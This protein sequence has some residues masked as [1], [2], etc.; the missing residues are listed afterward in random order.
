MSITIVNP[1]QSLLNNLETLSADRKRI[2]D[3]ITAVGRP[4]DLYPFQWVQIMAFVLEY[5]PDLILELGRGYGNST[6]AFIETCHLMQS[7]CQVVS[8]CLSDDWGTRTIPN[9]RKVVN[10][11]WFSPVKAYIVNLFDYDYSKVLAGKKRVVVFWDAHGFDIAEFV[12]GHILLMIK[13]RDHLVIMHDISDARYVADSTRFYGSNGIWK[14]KNTWDGPRIHV[15]NIDSCVEQSVAALDFCT[16]NR[17]PFHSADESLIDISNE[18]WENITKVFGNDMVSRNGHWFWFTLNESTV[19][20]TF[21]KVTVETHDATRNPDVEVTQQT[22]SGIKTTTPSGGALQHLATLPFELPLYVH[23]YNNILPNLD[24][25]IED[26]SK[27][28]AIVDTGFDIVFNPTSRKDHLATPYFQILSQDDGG[29]PFVRVI[30][31]YNG[32]RGGEIYLQDDSYQFVTTNL[33]SPLNTGKKMKDNILTDIITLDKQIQK[34]RLMIMSKT[35]D[36][37]TLPSLIKI[38]QALNHNEVFDAS[39]NTILFDHSG[40]EFI[41]SVETNCYG[42]TDDSEPLLAKDGHMQFIPTSAKDHI[43]TPMFRPASSLFG[44]RRIV[45]MILEW[46]SPPSLAGN[47]LMYIQNQDYKIIS[48]NLLSPENIEQKRN[49]NQL[50][51][52][53]ALNDSVSKFRAVFLSSDGNPIS[54][55]YTVQITQSEK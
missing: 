35:G 23:A 34:L 38:E 22:L 50:I 17:I 10:D 37:V 12:F 32:D 19:E 26:K 47:R 27:P 28:L 7:P 33:I 13:D 36:M 21:P 54:I 9:L 44:G 30:L 14:G 39:F 45:K 52:Y 5:Q 46:D 24:T 16:R 4:T 48:G 15:A 2:E 29:L 20:M 18:Q 25:V 49:G 1:A 41:A 11:N 43:A 51:D 3:L 53:V 8:L 40:N 6:C 42:D 55:P 31:K